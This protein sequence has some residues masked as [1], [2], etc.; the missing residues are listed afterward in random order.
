MESQVMEEHP[1][2]TTIILSLALVTGRE[3][4]LDKVLIGRD[5]LA[6][7]KRPNA[8]NCVLDIDIEESSGRKPGI[9]LCSS[10]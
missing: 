3:L 4:E 7:E 1:P 8:A 5:S 10:Y 2:T 9:S 6:Q